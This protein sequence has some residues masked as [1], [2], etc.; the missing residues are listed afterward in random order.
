MVWTD[1]EV[2]HAIDLADLLLPITSAERTQ[3]LD[4]LAINS[5]GLGGSMNVKTDAGVLPRKRVPAR[6]YLIVQL[7]KKG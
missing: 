2:P 4:Q 1:G 6:L 3:F 5:A 7:V